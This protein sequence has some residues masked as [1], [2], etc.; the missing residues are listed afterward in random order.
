MQDCVIDAGR[1]RTNWA[2]KLNKLVKHVSRGANVLY[3]INGSVDV[4]RC[5]SSW[6]KHYHTVV[7]RGL[8]PDPRTAP[9]TNVTLCC[10]HAY[11]GSALPADDNH[12]EPAPCITA[13]SVP[14]SHLM[15]LVKFR[16]NSHDLAI[17]RLRRARPRVLR[18]DRLCT[19]V[20]RRTCSRPG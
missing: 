10:Y 20:Q 5:L 14:Y 3:P 8:A 1:G 6:R 13:H 16:T 17:D 15:S 2:S 11:F 7:W 19:S 4:D 9:S 18:A 12:W